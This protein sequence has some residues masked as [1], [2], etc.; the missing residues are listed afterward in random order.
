LERIGAEIMKR[1]WHPDASHTNF[2]FYPDA[3]NSR[4]VVNLP[5]DAIG[6][7]R[8]LQDKYGDLVEILLGD[9][10]WEPLPTVATTAP[11]PSTPTTATTAAA[12]SPTTAPAD[13]VAGS[14]P[15]A[16]LAA[17]AV[18]AV[19]LVMVVRRRPTG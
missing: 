1:D 9:F 10:P 5:A 11:A 3:S 12:A 18:V 6:P 4:L 15:W 14:R 2:G 13:Q 17:A 16:V 7:A 19:A 8:A